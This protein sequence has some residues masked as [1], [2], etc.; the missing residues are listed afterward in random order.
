[1]LTSRL[2][3]RP[4]QL[5]D[6]PALAAYRSD[7]ATAR[8]QPWLTPYTV[9]DAEKLISEFVAKDPVTPGW[10]QYGIELRSDGTL[11]GD[12]GVNL[13]ANGMQAEIG[14]TIAA[15]QQGNGYGT[16]AVRRI[17]DRLFGEQRLHRVSA[18]CDARN[19]ASARLL[20]RVGFIQEGCRRSATWI[21]GEWTDDLVFGL[22]ADEWPPRPGPD[23]A[24][25]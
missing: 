23:A 8:F 12:L 5:A 10:F 4:L 14:Y 16:E 11:I 21:K 17:L 7:P 2:A 18:E 9:G 24:H 1:M 15:G 25:A 20:K 13:D 22:L 19:V 3:L 6:A